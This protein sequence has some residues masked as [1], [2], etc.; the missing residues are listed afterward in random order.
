MSLEAQHM[1]LQHPTEPKHH[2]PTAKE[3]ART[4]QGVA[5]GV[6]TVAWIVV[7]AV[8][9]APGRPH[10]Y[11][12]HIALGLAVCSTITTGVV[13][14]MSVSALHRAQTACYRSISKTALGQY[15]FVVAELR[16]LR[17]TIDEAAGQ[18]SREHEGIDAKLQPHYWSAYAD[19]VQDATGTDHHRATLVPFDRG[20]GRHGGK[21]Q[22]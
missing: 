6:A 16:A 7:V 15:E 17:R 14:W 5:I 8:V 19:G 2:I 18:H 10:G 22:D 1:T 13:A 21:R 12:A 20:R 11:G 4:W 3:S 9:L